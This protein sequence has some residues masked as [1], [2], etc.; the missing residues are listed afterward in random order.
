MLSKYDF[1]KHKNTY[2]T[3][4]SLIRLDFT[5]KTI[6]I[7]PLRAVTI[8]CTPPPNT[9]PE[10]VAFYVVPYLTK[11]TVNPLGSIFLVCVLQ[12][13]SPYESHGSSLL[14]YLFHFCDAN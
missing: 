7:A 1:V 5:M 13:K 14:F 4:F 12:I 8:T 3:K 11:C 10:V 6:K 9:D 2:Y